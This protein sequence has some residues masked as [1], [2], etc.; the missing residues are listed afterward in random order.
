MS[1]DI[2]WQ[3]AGDRVAQVLRTLDWADPD[4]YADWL[5]QTYYYVRET[6]RYLALAA[7]RFG[8]EHP[9]LHDRLLDNALEERGHER[10]L[11][12]D[13]AAIRRAL[14]EHP[15]SVATSIFMNDLWARIEREGPASLYGRLLL[16]EGLAVKVGRELV[17]VITRHHGAQA[18]TFLMLHA[19]ADPGHVD[20]A[21]ASLVGISARD[22]A[23]IAATLEASV[24]LY[25]EMLHAI[26]RPTPA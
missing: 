10:Y 22:E 3:A 15:Q 11:L 13:L 20:K 21:L 19:D 23:R 8:H 12:A 24:L 25:L 7:A 4:V 16:L 1:I 6:T 2:D 14:H 17:E 5:A 9:H 18:A 26:R